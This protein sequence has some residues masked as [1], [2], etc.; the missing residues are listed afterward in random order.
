VVVSEG[1]VVF[2]STTAAAK[3]EIWKDLQQFAQTLPAGDKFVFFSN[4]N[5][6]ELH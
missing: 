3:P 1:C 5:G 4:G 2:Y 6:H